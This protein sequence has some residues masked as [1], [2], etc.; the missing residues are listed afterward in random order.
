MLGADAI[1]GLNRRKCP[2]VGWGARQITG[3]AV[4]VADPDAQKRLRWKW[5]AEEVSAL[6]VAMLLLVVI[7]ASLYFLISVFLS[8][9][10]PLVSATGETVSE[11][12]ASTGLAFALLYSWPVILVLLLRVFPWQGLVLPAGLAVLA[13][14][15]GRGLAM[16][17]AHILVLST[18]QTS[19]AKS[20]IWLVMDPVDWT[21][22]IIGA[23]LFVRALRLSREASAILPEEAQI[24]SAPRKLWLRGLL[25][26]TGVYALVCLGWVGV[27]RYDESAHLVQEGVDP[28]REHEALLALNEGQRMPV[29]GTSGPPRSHSNGARPLGGVNFKRNIPVNLPD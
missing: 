8:G 11:S 29:R 7:E 27:S 14:T 18:T 20:W 28:Q 10:S 1:I 25:A 3:Q 4:R 12:I 24:V 6:T 22:I 21:F 5:Y 2:E 17:A 15:T 13:V 19:Q 23:V 26:A 9:K 16:M